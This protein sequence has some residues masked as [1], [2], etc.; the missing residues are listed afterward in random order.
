M[1][2]FPP[3]RI[4][5]DDIL[6][7]DL[8]LFDDPSFSVVMNILD[9]GDFTLPTWALDQSDL[10][11]FDLS[12]D[13]YNFGPILPFQDTAAV[14]GDGQTWQPDDTITILP[15]TH[16]DTLTIP[17]L[18]KPTHISS[19]MVF[20]ILDEDRYSPPGISTES[21]GIAVMYGQSQ[22]GSAI[23]P[24][25]QC[26]N[27]SPPEGRLQTPNVPETSCQS[28]QEV[29]R[30]RKRTVE[31]SHDKADSGESHKGHRKR[32]SKA[33]P[34]P[35]ETWDLM[36]SDITNCYI[37]EEKTMNQVKE[38]LEEKF[39]DRL[40]H[41]G[42]KVEEKQIL[43]QLKKWKIQK[44]VRPKQ[45]EYI[46]RKYLERS[47]V[48][49]KRPLKFFV[50]G[51]GISP[52]KIERWLKIWIKARQDSK[53]GQHDCG[54]CKWSLSNNLRFAKLRLDS[55]GIRCILQDILRDQLQRY[56]YGKEYPILPTLIETPPSLSSERTPEDYTISNAGRSNSALE[57]PIIEPCDQSEQLESF[58][59]RTFSTILFIPFDTDCAALGRVFTDLIL[60]SQ[61]YRPWLELVQKFITCAS[62]SSCFDRIG[63]RE[64]W[65][66]EEKRSHVVLRTITHRTVSQKSDSCQRIMLF[67]VIDS[68]ENQK[69]L[70]AW[71]DITLDNELSCMQQKR[72]FT[73]NH[74]GGSLHHD[75][76]M[77]IRDSNCRALEE[78]IK[79]Q[80]ATPN[81][82]WNT[83][84]SSLRVCTISTM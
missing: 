40:Q 60:S 1:S 74:A 66:W 7:P 8:M 13:E 68:I 51:V 55:R 33:K 14:D 57:S 76:M 44:Y 59:L 27:A 64:R 30:K 12:I 11:D 83:Q 62:R 72:V 77:I 73:C 46:I 16:N 53:E 47:K 43:D 61:T 71:V 17:S 45:R 10:P 50:R 52:A 15:H 42:G 6:S 23:A 22:D 19:P 29:T 26:D 28:I 20:D 69:S 4:S 56:Y 49:E 63:T 84:S 38:M 3:A 18:L 80:Q 36:K 32:K 79:I 75:S 2:S 37:T 67:V 31:F 34:I 82:G 58:L 78:N 70:C 48:K 5:V 35:Q 41:C 24:V 81:D 21:A 65:T 54:I 9:N 39:L 25:Y